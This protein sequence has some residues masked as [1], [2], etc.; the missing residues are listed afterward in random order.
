MRLRLLRR[1]CRA[2]TYRILSIYTAKSSLNTNKMKK[3]LFLIWPLLLL[4]NRAYAND[5]FHA[6]APSRTGQCLLVTQIT[7]HEQAV[8]F[9]DP[10]RLDLGFAATTIAAHP[11]LPVLY[12]S[13][14]RG[15]P[16]ASVGAVIQLKEDGSVA[17]HKQVTFQHGYSYPLP[18]TEA[19]RFLLGNNYSRR[20]SRCVRT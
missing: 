3:C 15:D 16:G 5:A 19:N 7:A 13:T 14:N 10:Q 8:T 11:T 18:S 20:T 2:R 4:T 6:Y 12:I 9:S 17:S 1:A